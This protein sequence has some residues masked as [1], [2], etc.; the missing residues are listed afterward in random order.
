VEL[1][2]VVELPVG[3]LLDVRHRER[4]FLLVQLGDDRAL[5]GFER[6]GF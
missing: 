4:R 3:Q 6:G 1:H 2:T 5:V